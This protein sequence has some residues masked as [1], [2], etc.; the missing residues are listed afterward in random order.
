LKSSTLSIAALR[1]IVVFYI[2]HISQGLRLWAT[3][4]HLL[5]RLYEMNRWNDTT[6]LREIRTKK[7]QYC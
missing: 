6:G 3:G 5:R 7:K 4:L 1:G 2:I